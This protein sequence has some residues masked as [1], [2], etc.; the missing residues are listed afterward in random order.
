MNGKH[1]SGFA[2]VRKFSVAISGIIYAIR[3]QNSFLV[4]LPVAF[5]VVAV[6]CWLRLESWRWVAITFAI[7]IVIS[8]ELLNTAI[9]EMVA[10]VHPEHHPRIGRALD[11]AAGAVFVATV[12]AIVVGLIT[13]GFPLWKAILSGV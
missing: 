3:H 12:G 7:T 4:H 13:L 10:V 11:T 6:G 9:E 2:I 8:A 5:A 1:S